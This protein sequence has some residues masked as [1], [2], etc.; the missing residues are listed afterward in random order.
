MTELLALTVHM[1]S[2]HY[3]SNDRLW[4]SDDTYYHVNTVC[5][6]SLSRHYYRK[7]NFS[8]TL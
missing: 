7:C 5:W 2:T 8:V 6:Y 3:V 1:V 4:I